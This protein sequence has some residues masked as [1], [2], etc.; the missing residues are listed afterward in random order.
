MK[1]ALVILHEKI[2]CGIIEANFCVNCHD[3]FQ[4]EVVSEDAERVGKLAVQ[5]IEEAGRYYN[6]RCPTTGEYKIGNS[7]KD[8]H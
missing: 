1:K 2:K 3:E 7:W 4:I 8:T 5:S 6:L